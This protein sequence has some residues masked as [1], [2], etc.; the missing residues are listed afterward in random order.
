MN[1]KNRVVL[2]AMFVWVPVSVWGQT[3]GS[4]TGQLSYLPVGSDLLKVMTFNIRVDTILDG[5]NR[6]GHRKKIVYNMI[7]SQQADIVGLQESLDFQ[8]DY[9]R[10]Q[11]GDYT[12]YGAG[13]S[14]GKQKGE[15]C[16]IF[17]R[18]ERFALIDSGTFWFSDT[19]SVPGSKD[20]GA[21]CPRICSWVRLLDKESLSSF[22]VYN[23]HLDNLSQNSRKKSVQLLASRIASRKGSDPFIV[24]G[25]FN[26]ETDNSAMEYLYNSDSETPYPRMTNA[27]GA[28]HA[29]SDEVGTRH[30]FRGR[31]SGP[32]IDHIP[33][34]DGFEA[35]NVR[36]D[37]RHAMN[38]RYPSDH[39]PVVAT[40]RLKPVYA[41]VFLKDSQREGDVRP[42]PQ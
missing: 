31:I 18:T 16:P 10:Q 22:F 17:Y 21:M 40:V 13:R 5:P 20:W 37:Q 32:K 30:G 36:I 2:F 9:L 26:M 38:G 29:D 8:T 28:V 23:V 6:W 12:S 4:D 35:L 15:A 27:W 41:A 3:S 39:F 14:D 25:D 33:L 7:V 11:L 1:L 42:R 34:S 24:L 19:P